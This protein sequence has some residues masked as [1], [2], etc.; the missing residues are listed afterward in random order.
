MSADVWALVDTTGPE[1]PVRTC[2]DHG[3]GLDVV[4]AY[5]TRLNRQYLVVASYV[6]FFVPLVLDRRSPRSLVDPY[7]DGDASALEEDPSR[8]RCPSPRTLYE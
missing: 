2:P 7:V 4:A 3:D 1:G 8:Q 6:A 5:P